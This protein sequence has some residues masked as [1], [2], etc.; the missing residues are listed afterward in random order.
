MR[1]AVLLV[2]ASLSTLPATVFADDELA[3]PM[4][5][6]AGEAP[7]SADVGHAAPCF[8]DFDRDGKRDLLVGQMG[9]GQMLI[10]RNEG[11]DKAP[12]FTTSSV[13][14]VDG[15]DATIEAG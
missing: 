4:R 11:T 1:P 9:K 10:W 5:I 8:H 7:I 6:L 15:K 14:R 13:F 3:P 12:A 2:A